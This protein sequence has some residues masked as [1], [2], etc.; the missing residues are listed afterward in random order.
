MKYNQD[1]DVL[2][3][4]RFSGPLILGWDDENLLEMSLKDVYFRTFGFKVEKFLIYVTNIGIG[5]NTNM[6]GAG[7]GYTSSFIGEY[8]KKR[9]LFVQRIEKNNCQ[10][11][12]YI[13]EKNSITFC[14]ANPNDTWKNVGL[15]K[16][17][18]GTELFGLEHPIIQK[19]IHDKQ[20]RTISDINSKSFFI[21]WL[22]QHSTIIELHK[23]L[24]K[25]YPPNYIFD[26]RELCAWRTML[27]A[28]GCINITP[29][30]KNESEYEFWTRNEISI[31]DQNIL[32]DLYNNGFLQAIPNYIT[33]VSKEFWKCFEESLNHSKNWNDGKIR[34]LSIITNNFTYEEL[35]NRLKVS[36]K[37]IAKA[38]TYCNINDQNILQDLYNNGFLQ[39]IPNYITNVSK[40]FWKC[41]EESLNHSKNWNDGKIRILSIITNNFTYEELQNRLKVSSKIIAKAR[42]YCNINGLGCSMLNK[43]IITR[44]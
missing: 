26:V 32:Q 28:I 19:I 25:L 35:Q 29:F 41:F 6:M 10:I 16:K 37:I 44:V 40:E 22:N 15:Y 18:C 2:P 23:K 21:D 17:F 3:A 9:A 42:T 33:N 8:E 27:K 43:P 39:A 31:I 11:T 4:T 1:I 36:S 5:N 24:Q 7:I 20:Y 14:G 34:I 38:R 30:E 12:I 13:S